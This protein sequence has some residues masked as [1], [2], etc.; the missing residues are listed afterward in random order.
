MQT[1]LT[2]EK[3]AGMWALPR[4]LGNWFLVSRHGC[5]AALVRTCCAHIAHN[6]GTVS[7]V[8]LVGFGF[9]FAGVVCR[10]VGTLTAELF[11]T[12]VITLR[13]LLLFLFLC[14]PFMLFTSRSEDF[15]VKSLEELYE[16]SH[17]FEVLSGYT[18]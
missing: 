17:T 5:V 13:W 4:A 1:G 7:D 16:M 6:Q 3:I 9:V 11:W 10:T 14:F 15:A 8:D 2:T 18:V 12:N